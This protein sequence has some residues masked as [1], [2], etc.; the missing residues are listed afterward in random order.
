ME[1]SVKEYLN[2]T[3]KIKDNHEYNQPERYGI[4]P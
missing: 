4:S 3:K 2:K 1:K